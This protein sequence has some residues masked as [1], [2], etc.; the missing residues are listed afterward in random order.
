VRSETDPSQTNSA[1]PNPH[2]QRLTVISDPQ[3]DADSETAWY[4]LS[5]QNPIVEVAFL[6][7]VQEPYLEAKRGF[8][9]DGVSWKVR[10]DY[11]AGSIDFRGAYKNPGA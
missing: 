8:T 11:G 3:L 2:H 7:G 9:R 6:G 1:K 4:L 10:L 5:S